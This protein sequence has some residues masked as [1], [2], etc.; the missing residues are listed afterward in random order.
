MPQKSFTELCAESRF[1]L[2]VAH[3][4]SD[5]AYEDYVE[6]AFAPVK[7]T[8]L[9]INSS[10]SPQL[11]KIIDDLQISLGIESPIELY[12][13]N[14][15]ESNAYAYPPAP[16]SSGLRVVLFSGLVNL[17]ELNELKFVVAHE[18]GHAGLFHTRAYF[19]SNSTK[20]ELETLKI[21]RSPELLPAD[22][23]GL[24]DAEASRSL[25]ESD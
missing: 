20:T 24:L 5:P 22:R 13:V 19:D 2:D 1:Q 25:R 12:V 17:L 18:L 3:S 8:G 23:I 7:S 9:L 6:A 11:C 4:D 16:D 14:N 10:T 15:P 21:C